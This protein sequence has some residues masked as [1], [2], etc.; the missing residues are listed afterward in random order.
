V[1]SDILSANSSNLYKI[2][3]VKNQN[4]VLTVTVFEGNPTARV[5][6]T[7]EGINK[8]STKKGN[9]ISITVSAA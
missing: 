9:V 7:I 6:N 8:S 3:T 5:F 4:I 2:H 1:T